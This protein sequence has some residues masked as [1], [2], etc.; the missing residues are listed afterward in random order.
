MSN[1]PSYTDTTVV[2]N[3]SIA[4]MTTFDLSLALHLD[5]LSDSALLS[6]TTTRFNALNVF[7]RAPPYTNGGGGAINGVH[8]DVGNAS[9]LGRFLS[10]EV[11]KSW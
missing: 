9:P 10:V 8:Y 4:S 11:R 1:S 7:D 3:D 5:Q 6:G 2:P